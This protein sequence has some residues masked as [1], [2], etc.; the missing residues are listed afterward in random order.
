M[1]KHERNHIDLKV[2]SR[3][4]FP[5]QANRD[6][7]GTLTEVIEGWIMA[8]RYRVISDSGVEYTFK[9]NERVMPFPEPGFPV[10][11]SSWTDQHPATVVSVK[12]KQMIV[13]DDHYKIIKGSAQD[14]SAEYEYFEIPEGSVSVFKM[15]KDGSWVRD[16]THGI[17]G[18]RRYYY[19]PH[20]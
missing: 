9:G 19:D 17:V 13:R 5:R 16:V 3:V 4:T 12:G 7:S 8:D 1:K 10:T 11:Y 2:G 6:W 20:F 18:N 15:R 14:G